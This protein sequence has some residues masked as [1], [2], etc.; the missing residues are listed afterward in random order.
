MVLTQAQ[1]AQAYCPFDPKHLENPYAFYAHARQQPAFAMKTLLED[2]TTVFVVT[3]FEDAHFILSHPEL[4]SS[5][6]TLRPITSWSPEAL[7]VL[8]QGY[9][10]TPIHINTDGEAH[11]RFR[12]PLS[13]AFLPAR[14]A[15][16]EPSIRSHAHTLL[17]KC[18]QGQR[19]DMITDFAYPLTLDIILSLFHLPAEDRTQA[20]HWCDQWLALV[21]ARLAAEEQV[22]AAQEV[23]AFQHYLAKIIQHRTAE[24]LP[25]DL[26][27]DLTHTVG[28][29]TP[30]S[31]AELVNMLS[32]LLLA[33][34][35]TSTNM[36][37]NALVYLLSHREHWQTICQHPEQIP[38]YLEELLRYDTP[39]VSFFRT[40]LVETTVGSVA[41]P[42]NALL[43]L[44][45]GSTNRD[46]SIFQQADEFRPGRPERH[47]V[48]GR[49]PHFCLGASLA[50]LE[51]CI[52]LETVSQRCPDLSLVPTQALNHTKNL[53]FRGFEQV[54]VQW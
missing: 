21:S 53:M 15:A 25:D 48:F 10:P 40:A 16:L 46:E 5:R 6:D 18:E 51:G 8:A 52:A 29:Q 17:D 34:H 11:K 42:T 12:K 4:F 28:D 50:R 41:I 14:I 9:A 39:A 36:I 27:S 1:L 30:F 19:F 26:I 24:P 2:G 47:M 43:L 44:V 49:G 32:G 3:R 13:Q 23:V 20:K 22:V 37:G 7:A 54:S 35:E 38:V 33:G 45:F 31:L